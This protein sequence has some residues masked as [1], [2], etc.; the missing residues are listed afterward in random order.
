MRKLFTN[1]LRTKKSVGVAGMLM[2]LAGAYYFFGY[3]NAA[4]YQFSTV[5][6]GSIAETVSVTGNTI[7]VRSV[8]LGFGNSGIVARVYASVG[9]RV[10]AGSVLAA[11]G[12]GDLTAQLNQAKAS[13]DA[14]VAALEKLKAGAR[15]EDIASSE[16]ALAKGEQDLQ[17]LYAGVIDISIDAYTKAND[18]ARTQLLGFFTNGD[19]G[20][21]QL[22]YLTSNSQAQVNAEG[23]RVLAREAL[24]DWQ[25]DLRFHTSFSRGAEVDAAISKNLSR[26]LTVRSLVDNAG[27][28]LNGALTLDASTFAAYKTNVATA[29]G[30][31]NTA[32]KNLNTASQAIASQKATVDQLRS[33]LDLKKAGATI[34]EIAIQDAQIQQAKAGVE[35]IEARIRNS[36]IVAPQS[37]IIT[38][39]DV[40]IGETASL[41]TPLVSI[42]SDSAF[43]IEATVPETDIGKIM[44]RN[45]ARV[46]IDAF[47]GEVF[48]GRVFLI[49]PAQTNND[50]VVGYNVKIAF[51][52]VDPRMKSGL[53]ANLDI[54]TRRKD[55]ALLLPQYAIVQNDKGMFVETFRDKRVEQIPVVLGLQDQ[56]GNV[57]IVSGVREGER[58]IIVGLKKK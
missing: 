23:A 6:R 2:I 46:T 35:G 57:E 39:Y 21:P 34:Q 56:K 44:S 19:T 32:V 24:N 54:E 45:L 5:S 40:K 36:I 1:L 49:D 22:S 33:Q 14:Q 3:R 28:A 10:A 53:T 30:E 26:L 4:L 25:T 17:N 9:E 38:R 51:D 37:G 58:V 8:S 42:I 18:A 47:P 15:P 16:A 48:A 50:G 7:P 55:D 27:D 31:V 11:L 52:A 12:T 41:G 13:V 20:R 43:E 29:I